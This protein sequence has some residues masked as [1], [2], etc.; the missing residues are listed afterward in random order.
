MALPG[1]LG[2]RDVD[3]RVAGP[4][5]GRDVDRAV[6]L[7]ITSCSDAAAADGDQ[8]PEQYWKYEAGWTE[9]A[10]KQFAPPPKLGRGQRHASGGA[11]PA[12]GPSY[13]TPRDSLER[14]AHSR[15]GSDEGHSV[16]RDDDLSARPPCPDVADGLGGL[17]QR[18]RP[19]DHRAQLSGLHQ[20]R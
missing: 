3:D 8:E 5:R 20:L 17:A 16:D 10:S 19:I 6:E 9:R 1:F 11:R 13:R 15:C 18:E 7:A 2:I 4:C 12:D 14:V